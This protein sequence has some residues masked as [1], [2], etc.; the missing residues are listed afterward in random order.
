MDV[1]T[2]VFLDEV[3]FFIQ[4]YNVDV[5]TLSETWL[6]ESASDL[7]VCPNGYNLLIFRRDRNRRGC[8][9]AVLLSSNLRC[10]V[11][12][13]IFDSHIESLWIQLYPNTKQAVLV[14]CVH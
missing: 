8:G 13:D 14:C 6:D 11:C 2:V 3:L 9:V 7:E 4:L 5:M 12:P 10:R 1:V